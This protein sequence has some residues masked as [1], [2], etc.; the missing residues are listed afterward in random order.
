MYCMHIPYTHTQ[1]NTAHTTH[2]HTRRHTHIYIAHKHL[3]L[4]YYMYIYI[5]RDNLREVDVSPFVQPV[6][7]ACILP[8]TAVG[9][10][11]D[12]N[13]C[14]GNKSGDTCEDKWMDVTAEVLWAFLGFALLM[15][16]NR[17]PQ[18]HLYWSTDPVFHYFP[19]AGRIPRDR[20]FAI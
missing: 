7:P 4:D 17:L 16:I 20:F 6:G 11:P 2:T 9:V 5:Y 13:H 19:I 12:G 3:Q 10:F 1:H 14:G 15:G 8:S 18:L